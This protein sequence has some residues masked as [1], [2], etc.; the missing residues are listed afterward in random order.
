MSAMEATIGGRRGGVTARSVGRL[1]R[2]RTKRGANEAFAPDD[3][4]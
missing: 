1:D 2:H 4:P 3:R